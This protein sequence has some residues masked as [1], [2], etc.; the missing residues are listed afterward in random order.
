MN[1][2]AP[3]VSNVLLFQSVR[4]RQRDCADRGK[5]RDFLA[6]N[7]SQ[8]LLRLHYF[9]PQVLCIIV[10]FLLNLIELSRQ[11]EVR[12]A[13]LAITVDRERS[14]ALPLVGAITSLFE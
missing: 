12:S 5:C 6:R 4:Q 13:T 8:E 7:R 2:F 1:L 11:K 14:E 10:H 9:N 3:D